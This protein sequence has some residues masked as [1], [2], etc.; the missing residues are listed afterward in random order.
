MTRYLGLLCCILWRSYLT[1]LSKRLLRRHL[2]L[3]L[4][5][6]NLVWARKD[7]LMLRSGVGAGPLLEEDLAVVLVALLRVHCIGQ[8][9]LLLFIHGLILC[10]TQAMLIGYHRLSIMHCSTSRW[11]LS[12]P[13]LAIY[14]RR[15]C[16]NHLRLRIMRGLSQPCSWSSP[17]EELSR[18]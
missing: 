3:T 12:L 7:I 14:L 8:C 10:W 16:L 5:G 2:L 15:H 1:F 11:S 18:H 4:L 17:S 6:F 13:L 9:L